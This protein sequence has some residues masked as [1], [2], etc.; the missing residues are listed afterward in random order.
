MKTK[1]FL[2]FLLCLTSGLSACDSLSPF[3][4]DNEYEKRLDEDGDG[5]KRPDDCDDN[6]PQVTTFELYADLDGDGWGAGRAITGCTATT[7]LSL[8][9]GDCDDGDTDRH[10][11]GTEVCDDKDNNCNGETDEG[12]DKDYFDDIDR[13][14]FGRGPVVPSCEPRDNLSRNDLDCDD[15]NGDV[16]PGTIEIC[17][18]VDNNCV[19]G[20]DEGFNNRWYRDAD[21]DQHGDAEQSIPSCT[22]P[23]GFVAL[24]DDCDDTDPMTFTGAS[25]I[26]DDGIDQDCNSLIDDAV[27]ANEYFADADS[28]E[29]G[30]PLVSRYRCEQEDGW[31]RTGNDCDDQNPNIAPSVPEACADGVDNNCNGQVDEEAVETPWFEDADDDGFG[32]PEVTQIACAPPP[33]YVG[34]DQDCDDSNE[35][36]QPGIEE[37]CNNGVDDNCDGS[38]NACRLQGIQPIVRTIDL[39]GE[40][41][42]DEAGSQVTTGYLNEDDELDLVVSAPKH[43]TDFADTGVIYV[44]FGPMLEA[45]TLEEAD[46]TLRG[47]ATDN[48]AGTTVTVADFNGDGQDDLVAAA[49]FRASDAGNNVGKLYVV[50][51]PISGDLAL[52]DANVMWGGEGRDDQVGFAL[53][54]GDLNNDQQE[55]LLIT[56]T[57]QDREAEDAG[58]IYVLFGPLLNS[59]NL[60]EA[61][62]KIT[63]GGTDERAGFDLAVGDLNADQVNDLVVTSPFHDIDGVRDVGMVS[64]LF[65]PLVHDRTLNEAD[66]HLFGENLTD[67]AGRIVRIGD[68]NHDTQPDL[69]VS[70]P[71]HDAGGLN[72]TG[73]VYVLFG[74]LLEDKP[75]SQAD[76]RI[77]GDNPDDPIGNALAIHDIDGDRVDD[78]VVANR[79]DDTRV[80]RGGSVS[81]FYGPLV[82]VTRSVSTADAQFFGDSVGTLLGTALCLED[83]DG[84]GYTDLIA[85]AK[86][87]PRP[88][89]ATGGARII[90]GLGL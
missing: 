45:R 28:D 77:E 33:G 11:E 12:F 69:V 36:V 48:A 73:V 22:Q 31:V 7:T 49:P 55:D 4:S 68:L 13:D 85:G 27:N 15:N 25:E 37:V 29:E 86:G 38:V 74:P 10:P 18:L 5:M 56:S 90:Y 75:L 71:S 79:S 57:T 51:G 30:D 54:H 46:A 65:G 61:S 87:M 63:G 78:L 19:D 21:E 66:V 20:I 40:E 72:E 41:D 76:V 17:D 32:N 24:S 23:V 84:D 6:N 80:A 35:Q 42:S 62:I 3:I 47:E 82:P 88:P 67:A 58:T 81:L 14:G 64:I 70:A 8:K 1:V 39:L 83:V 16:F 60:A 89:F 34:N 50:N 44:F 53:T 43:N 26:C 2:S 52:A 9:K 59:G